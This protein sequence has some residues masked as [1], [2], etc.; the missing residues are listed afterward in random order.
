MTAAINDA[1]ARGQSY[2]G[3]NIRT[4]TE[5]TSS[6]DRLVLAAIESPGFGRTSPHL[7]VTPDPDLDGDGILNDQDNCRLTPNIDQRDTNGDGIGNICDPDFAP[8]ENDCIV[9]AA[10]LGALRQAFFST[11]TAPNWNPD[12]ELNGDGVVG[13]LELGIMKLYFFQ[14]PGPGLPGN[15]CSPGRSAQ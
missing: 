1:L 6:S 11:A 3:L 9:N 15:A 7:R 5:G 10:D 8:A 2:F 14:A 4:Q 13:T 12:A